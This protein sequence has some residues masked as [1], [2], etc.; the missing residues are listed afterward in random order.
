[1]S[2]KYLVNHISKLFRSSNEKEGEREAEA[3]AE[4]RRKGE[5]A[6]EED[7]DTAIDQLRAQK[8]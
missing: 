2:S 6:G 5:R 3:E 7:K 1:L 4:G 8:A